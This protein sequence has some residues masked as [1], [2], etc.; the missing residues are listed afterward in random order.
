VRVARLVAE[1]G[2]AFPVPSLK[3]HIAA[4][5]RRLAN[6]DRDMCGVHYPQLVSLFSAGGRVIGYRQSRISGLTSI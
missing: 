6:R 4:D 1:H 3:A 5:C 2:A